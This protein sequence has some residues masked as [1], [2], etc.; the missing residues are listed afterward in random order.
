MSTQ[1]TVARI[2]Y[3]T[4]DLTSQVNHQGDFIS[5]STSRGDKVMETEMSKSI[6]TSVD[7]E[8][9]SENP[10][11]FN[12]GG[13]MYP[14]QLAH[15]GWTD[16]G[17][18][19]KPK[20][21]KFL[22]F[23]MKRHVKF[24]VPEKY[25]QH[26]ID[27]L[28]ARNTRCLWGVLEKDFIL[29]P[30]YDGVVTDFY[31]T[32]DVQEIGRATCGQTSCSLQFQSHMIAC[33][34]RI[35]SGVRTTKHGREYVIGEDLSTNPENQQE[36]PLRLCIVQFF[37]QSLL[38]LLDWTT[39]HSSSDFI[40]DNTDEDRGEASTSTLERDEMIDEMIVNDAMTRN[41]G[42]MMYDTGAPI[43]KADGKENETQEREASVEEN[44]N[45]F[46]ALLFWLTSLIAEGRISQ[47]LRK[48]RTPDLVSSLPRLSSAYL[49]ND[50]RELWHVVTDQSFGKLEGEKLIMITPCNFATN[51]PNPIDENTDA[52]GGESN[53]VN[54]IWIVWV[55]RWVDMT[56]STTKSH[57]FLMRRHVKFKNRHLL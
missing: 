9:N 35:Q 50:T 37:K 38:S 4:E 23:L 42:A 24:K 46:R 34:Y 55:E 43:H 25:G 1:D 5:A 51:V 20:F 26:A 3:G 21:L 18:D 40:G 27:K 30:M 6:E 13:N 56:P 16:K 44:I 47:M 10:K 32:N 7:S 15:S 11:P 2:G 52:F 28:I 49:Y 53:L 12:D 39:A 57:S 19:M 33:V 22:G 29:L 31:F 54:R 41:R 17:T 45:G 48:C 8:A 14:T 36:N